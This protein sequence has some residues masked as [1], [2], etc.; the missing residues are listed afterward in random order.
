MLLSIIINVQYLC[1]RMVK[2]SVTQKRI[3][4]LVQTHLTHFLL[5][6]GSGRK[7]RE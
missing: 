1:C 6:I 4:V 7:S 2:L 3:S 5:V